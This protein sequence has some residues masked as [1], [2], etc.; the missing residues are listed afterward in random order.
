MGCRK[1]LV[2][3]LDAID[4]SDQPVIFR[5]YK[6]GRSYYISPISFDFEN[7][8]K[9]KDEHLCHPSVTGIESIKREVML[10][11]HAKVQ[12]VSFE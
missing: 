12:K 1:T 7:P 6:S 10:V 5:V 3:T 11:F 4:H 8:N 2:Y 9:Y